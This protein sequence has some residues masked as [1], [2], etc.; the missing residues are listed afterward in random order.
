[1]HSF[2]AQS[3]QKG[4]RLIQ[5]H[6]GANLVGSLSRRLPCRRW[7]SSYWLGKVLA[8]DEPFVGRF[9][10]GLIEVY[11]GDIATMQTFYLGFFEREVTMLCLEEIRRDPPDLIV[12]VGANFGYYPLLFGLETRGRTKAIAFEP[13]PVN[14]ARLKRN[15]D[16]NPGID[17][18]IV[19]KAVGDKDG[20]LV[21]FDSAPAGHHVWSRLVEVNGGDRRGWTRTLVPMTRLDAE[22]DRLGVD[23]V[24]LTLIDVEGNEGNVISGMADGLAR[25]RYKRLMVEF[26]PWAFDSADDVRQ[27]AMT[28]V[29][30]GYR[31]Y[32]IRHHPARQPDKSVSYYRFRFDAAT[33]LGE[34]TFDDLTE[35]EHF[36][37]EAIP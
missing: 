28:I 8:T 29:G 4:R 2:R 18:T 21:G 9:R 27:I 30:N 7:Q 24:P 23:R 3:L 14:V 16:L 5:P 10:D 11:P 36:W 31:G 19:P 20:T 22:L 15:A 12:D 6:R 37:F 25:R 26:H 13:D 1:M 35:W 33:V 32:R 17:V 34:M